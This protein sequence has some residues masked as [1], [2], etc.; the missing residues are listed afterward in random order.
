MNDNNCSV[1]LPEKTG[2]ELV[3]K[4]GVEDVGSIVRAALVVL[5]AVAEFDAVTVE[6]DGKG[7]LSLTTEFDNQIDFMSFDMRGDGFG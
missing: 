6:H 2:E 5:F 3:Q 4:F 1:E 7:V